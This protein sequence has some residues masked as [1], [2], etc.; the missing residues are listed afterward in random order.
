MIDIDNATVGFNFTVQFGGHKRIATVNTLE[1]L[2]EVVTS[3]VKE[4]GLFNRDKIKIVR[5]LILN[6]GKTRPIVYKTQIAYH[7]FTAMQRGE[8]KLSDFD[9]AI[10]KKFRDVMYREYEVN[11]RAALRKQITPTVE[12]EMNPLQSIFDTLSTMPRDM[13]E[14]KRDAW[15]YGIVVGWNSS[16]KEVADKHNWSPKDRLRLDTLHKQFTELRVNYETKTSL[17]NDIDDSTVQQAFADT[18][19]QAES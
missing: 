11:E 5:Q 19:L 1:R 14:Y 18:E 6:D 4:T 12:A 13:A 9:T 8:L 2:G 16:F 10:A 3:L 17:Q 7:Q 15:V